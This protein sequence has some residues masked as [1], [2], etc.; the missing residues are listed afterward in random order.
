[1]KKANGVVSCFSAEDIEAS[2]NQ[3]NIL[4]IPALPVPLQSSLPSLPL[5]EDTPDIPEN[6]VPPD[7]DFEPETVESDMPTVSDAASS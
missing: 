6:V 5:P 2:I 4:D 3:D 7:E 1:L